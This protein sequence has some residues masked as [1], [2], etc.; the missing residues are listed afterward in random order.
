MRD[1]D[2]ETRLFRYPLS[3]M[4]YDPL[5]DALPSVAKEEVCRK[6][7]DVLTGKDSSEKY[8]RLSIQDRRTIIKI[9]RDTKPDLPSYW[10]TEIDS[11]KT[12]R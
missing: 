10:R 4:I 1:F 11:P 7:F 2:L 6:L 12:S 5:F 3:Y 8:A 9:L